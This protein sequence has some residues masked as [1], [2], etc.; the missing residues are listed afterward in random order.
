[1]IVDNE[2]FSGVIRP[3]Y[4]YSTVQYYY[5]GRPVREDYT[6]GVEGKIMI[7][8]GK[9][10]LKAPDRKDF[11]YDDKRK[12]LID[13]LHE[14]ARN[15]YKDFIKVATDEELDKFE[16]PI[17]SYLDVQEYASV[18]SVSEKLFNFN[19]EDEEDT[20]EDI[21]E[22][23]KEGIQVPD[24]TNNEQVVEMLNSVHALSFRGKST[25]IERQAGM[26]EKVLAKNKK[27]VY[28]P[29]GCAEMYEREIR[30]IEYIGFVVLYARNRLYEKAF[31][32]FG[33]QQ[34]KEFR[35]YVS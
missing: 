8:H 33:V 13:K 25:R 27:V 24:W 21:E 19:V 12:A 15:M 17:E 1:M 35:N 9:V 14:E 18:L 11:I 32:Y 29:T 7:K 5:E 20:E 16:E 22:N 31:E 6:L 34:I 30:E 4:G 26:L 28:V 10:T 2:L 23:D 3:A